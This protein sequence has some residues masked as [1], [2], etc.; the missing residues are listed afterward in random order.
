MK[1]FSASFGLSWQ[2]L[3]VSFSLLFKF[4]LFQGRLL[5]FQCHDLCFCKTLQITFYE[6]LTGLKLH[7]KSFQK[8]R[9]EIGTRN[10]TE[11]K[12]F[13][14]AE[15]RQHN[16]AC[17]CTSGLIAVSPGTAIGCISGLKLQL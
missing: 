6:K 13:I 9:K 10:S 8:Q 14:F 11:R 12:E 1:Q 16:L 5:Q 2:I 17:T 7:A 15:D 3:E 4:Y